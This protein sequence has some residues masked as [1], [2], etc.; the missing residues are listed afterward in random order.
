MPTVRDMINANVVFAKLADNPN[1]F[2][3]TSF[4]LLPLLKFLTVEVQK[5]LGAKE[6]IVAKDSSVEDKEKELNEFLDREI[7]IP[8]M[9]VGINTLRNCGLTMIDIQHISWW[10]V[11]TTPDEEFED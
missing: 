1:L 10:L 3:T 7:D 11:E 2:V 5:Y 9:A 4:K 8:K 6:L